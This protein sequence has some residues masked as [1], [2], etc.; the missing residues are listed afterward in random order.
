MNSSQIFGL[1][2]GIANKPSKNDKVALVKEGMKSPEFA[3]VLTHAYNPFITFGMEDVPEGVAVDGSRPGHFEDCTWTLLHCLANRTLTG[4]AARTA[5]AKELAQLE[6]GSAELLKRI[7]KKDLRAGFGE[8]TINKAVPGTIAEFPYMRCSLPPKSN[9]P[10]W[11]WSVGIISQEKADG[12]FA[13]VNFDTH[14]SLW[15]TSRQGS[16]IPLD[17]LGAFAQGLRDTLT[18]GTQTHGELLV[19]KDGVV[20]PREQGNGQLNSII[21]GGKLDAGCTIMLQAWDQIPLS[22]VKPKGSY[23][24]HYR[25]RLIDLIEQLKNSR[26]IPVDFHPHVQIVPTKVVYSKAEA[27]EH[28]RELLKLGKEGTVCKHPWA[29]WRDHTSKDQVKLKLTA[30][31]ELRMRKLNPGEGKNAATFGSVQCESE[32]GK[33]VV[34]VSGFTDA[35]REAIFKDWESLVD[36]VMCVNSNM[37]LNPGESS[38][39]HSLFLPRFVELCKDRSTADTLERIREQFEAAVNAV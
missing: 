17:E 30:P 36:G 27:Y 22:E 5:V 13:N 10:G 35:V 38:D 12:M 29:I 33:L 25:K 19:F 18:P 9:M 31:C 34:N 21:Q 32:C 28:Y 11:D 2:D 20:L 1:I 16:P 24:V 26:A 14:G 23:A 15:V 6:P 39:V 4:D 8:S 3:K 37:I 7:I